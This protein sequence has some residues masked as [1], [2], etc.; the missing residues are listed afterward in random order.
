MIYCGHEHLTLEGSF[1]VCQ[2][3]GTRFEISE[4]HEESVATCVECNQ[5]FICERDLQICDNCIDEF[6]TDRLWND[7]DNGVIDALDFN[8]QKTVR[9]RYRKQV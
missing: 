5:E 8:E 2:V 4:V 9:E 7:H 3:C 6:D 1:Y